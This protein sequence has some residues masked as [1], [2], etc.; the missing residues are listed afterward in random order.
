MIKPRTYRVPI[1][2]AAVAVLATA[3]PAQQFFGVNTFA[4]FNFGTGADTLFTFDFADPSTY[5][6]PGIPIRRPNG[7][8]INGINGLDFG[9]D[10]DNPILYAGKI[11][12]PTS[13]EMFTIDPN[14]GIATSLGILP[15]GDFEGVND[16]AWDPVT[17][18]LYAITNN[19]LWANA[20]DPA[21]AVNLG[22]FNIPFGNVGLAFDS[23]GNIH[24]HDVVFDIIYAGTGVTTTV[25]ELHALPFDS[26]S[27]QGL[28]IDWSRDDQG[29]HA[30][31]SLDDGSAPNYLFGSLASGGGYSFVSEFDDD[32]FLVAQVGD[33]TRR[34]IPTP[35]GTA[36]LA[37]IGFTATHRRR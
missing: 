3:A 31:R 24:V 23:R 16:L 2:A 5:V 25:S 12:G 1:A 17:Q 37:L 27:S 29:Y 6:P 33:L 26:G 22:T 28:F 8:G 13:G 32:P 21:N 20:D 7:D 14:T 11:F 19:T 36:L 10:V 35:G 15:V 34:P 30:G 18:D 9:G 4:N